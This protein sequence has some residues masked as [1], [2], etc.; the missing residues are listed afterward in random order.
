MNN[1]NIE[2]KLDMPISITISDALQ[3][4]KGKHEKEGVNLLDITKKISSKK[5]GKK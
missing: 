3:K 2:K 5:F 1:E 4:L